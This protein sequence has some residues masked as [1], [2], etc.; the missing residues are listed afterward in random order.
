MT[1][2]TPA[3]AGHRD[4]DEFWRPLVYKDGK[5]DEEAVLNELADY[6][7]LMQQ[8]SRVYCEV[9]GGVLSKTNYAAELILE[10]H[11]NACDKFYKGIYDEEARDANP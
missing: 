1:E 8:A 11:Q 2:Q 6:R 9:T 3:G 5:L 7:F 10:Y 4:S